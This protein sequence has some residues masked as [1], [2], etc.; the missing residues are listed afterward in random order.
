MFPNFNAW[1][2]VPTDADIPAQTPYFSADGGELLSHF[3]R[4][5]SARYIAEDRCHDLDYYTEEPIL[6]PD[7]EKVEERA[8]A[9]Y[10]EMWGTG[11]AAYPSRVVVACDFSTFYVH[12]GEHLIGWFDTFNEAINYAQK[13]ARRG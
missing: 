4:G 6:S 7:E 11:V 5:R 10:Y 12:K 1:H 8:R 2:K 9:M 3:G 13:E